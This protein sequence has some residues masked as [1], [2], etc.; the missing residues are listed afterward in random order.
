MRKHKRG[1]VLLG[2]AMALILA[3]TGVL[4]ARNHLFGTSTNAG[5]EVAIQSENQPVTPATGSSATP[6]PN[7]PNTQSQ[8]QA[9]PAG[10]DGWNPTYT[11]LKADLVEYLD[12][13]DGEWSIYFKDLDSGKTFG[14]SPDEPI[15][16]ASTVK[17]PVVLYASRL[18]S[19]GKLSWDEQLTYVA[20]RDYRTGS[21][22]LQYTAED[23]DKFTIRQLCDLAI[24]E[25][26]NVAWKMLERRLGVDNIA[27]F[28]EQLGGETVYPDGQNVSTARDMVAYMQA[29][30]SFGQKD[31]GGKQ[32]LYDL[33]HTIWN[34]GL[35]RFIAGEVTVAHKEGDVNGVSN[36]VGVVYADHP[37]VVAVMSK[38]Q[39]DV[40]AGFQRIGEISRLIYQYQESLSS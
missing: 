25:S 14:I 27:A 26:D 9:T 28:M 32:L 29:A 20:S 31:S 34:T 24:V 15:P 12:G 2:A 33:A 37:Y 11:A 8:P 13:V 5:P 18:A 10:D 23:G 40:E 1:L 17:V 4:A 6:V 22:S 30:L 36:D 7:A 3:S 16:A 19:Q 35:N 38:G 21:G 39:D